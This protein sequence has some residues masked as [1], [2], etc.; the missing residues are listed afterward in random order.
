MK[1]RR[2]KNLIMILFMG[3]LFIGI[4]YA[5]LTTTLNISGTTD[6]DANTWNVYWDNVQVTTG[7][8]SATTPTIDTGKTTVTFSAHLS[9]PGDFYEFTVDAKNDGTIDAMI[10]LITQTM[11]IPNYINYRVTYGDGIP[12]EEKQLLNANAKETYKV[13]VEYNTDID[14]GDLPNTAQSLTLTYGT[15]YLQADSTAT[16]VL[17]PNAFATDDWETIVSAVK[18]GATD[19]YH[20]GDTKT[21]NLVDYRTHTV[22]IANMSNPPECNDPNFSQTACGFVIEF[23]DYITVPMEMSS[24][25]NTNVGGWPDTKIRTYL[26]GTFYNSLPNE[27][28]EGIMDTKVISSHGST[29]GESNF[30]STDKSYLL[31]IHEV[32]EDVDGNPNTGIDYNDSAYNNTRQLDYYKSLGITTSN[33]EGIAKPGG[34]WWT[35]T[36]YKTNPNQY[37]CVN[38]ENTYY[39]SIISAMV[40]ES[41]I[42]AFR[43]GARSNN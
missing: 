5:F 32:L 11:D 23:I 7:S 2:K 12:I 22:R 31:S 42:P 13:R 38:G 33:F 35:R 30:T 36:A 8:V 3:I 20:V 16:R 40:K 15:T 43:I 24:Y 6:V 39:A 1:N 41:V 17:H 14:P 18:Y 37:F 25:E 9:K 4:G 21:F 19:K 10:D 28:Q 26:N 34:V 29:A 27:L